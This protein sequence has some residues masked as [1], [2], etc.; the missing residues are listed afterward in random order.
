LVDFRRRLAKTDPGKIL[1][2]I[3]L[4]ETLDRA[5]DKGELRRAQEAILKRWHAEY[6]T[7]K[8]VVLKL[9]TGQGKTLI[10]L[11]IL[12][13][14]LNEN[15]G[16]AVYLCP[17]TFLIR[18]TCE[19]AKQFGV[20]YCLA[21]PD[22]PADFIDGKSLLITSVQKL[23]NGLT[24]FRLG[25]RSVPVATLVMDD[26]H[27]CVEDIREQLTIRLPRSHPAYQGLRELFAATLEEQGA[28]TWADIRANHYDALMLVPYWDWHDKH[29][30]VV[31]I[32]ASHSGD[33]E[34]KY[35][36]QLLRDQIN[37]CH[38]VVSGEALEIAPHLPPL[39]LFGSYH[40]ATH[41]VFMSATVTDDS[42]LVKG[43]RLSPDTIRRP[44]VYDKERWS[45]EKMILLPSLIHPSLD[46]GYIIS[47]FGGPK[48][49]RTYGVVALC[50][51]AARTKGWE[52]KGATITTKKTIDRAL[53]GLKKGHC[54]DTVVV[55]NRYDGIVLPDDAC[56][57]LIFDS[58]PHSDSLIDR[59][60]E[61]CRANSDSTAMRLARTIEQG[62]G[63]S[64]RGEKDYSVVLMTGE[65]LVKTVR[66]Q[67][68]RRH[69]S[70]QTRAQIEIGLEIAEMA[71][72]DDKDLPPLDV[73]RGVINKCL[74]RDED[75]KRFYV[76]HMDA[77]EPVPSTSKALDVFQLELEAELASASGDP[78]AAIT[79][80][81][82][83][84]DSYIT[85]DADK[86]W[87]LQEMGRYAYL[88]SKADSN[89]R[90]V[91]AHL[92]N[93]YVL[94]PRDGMKVD[95]L[96]ISQ[97]RVTKVI[98]WIR[99]FTDYSDLSVTLDD[100]VSRLQFGV[101]A[102]SFEQALGELGEALGFECQRPDKEWGRGP[103]NLWALRDGQ[104]LLIEC[105]NQ[106]HADRKEVYKDEAGQMNTSCAWFAQTY[107]GAT[108]K[109]ILITPAS[110]LGPGAALADDVELMRKS[111]LAKLLRN[112]RAFFAE[113]KSLDFKDLSAKAVQQL[114]DTHALSVEKLLKDYSRKARPAN[115]A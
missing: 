65:E 30:E 79:V 26:S 4:Y 74:K 115:G 50:P 80:V 53:D 106:V 96:V 114:I 62:L 20:R 38:C 3:A 61:S 64:V 110:K 56:R 97:Q 35:A 22:L 82:R 91:A 71:Q 21:E 72:E 100:I 49:G 103:D 43:L 14:K 104:Y 99:R 42:F 31:S 85:D 102:D 78:Q 18:Q 76:E 17:N 8:D 84:I 81:Q 16:P 57:L 52:A 83:L 75:W 63:R 34:I 108:A 58:R 12:Q 1:D 13:S 24:K 27:A 36:W 7:Q 70:P 54:N 23:F 107:A 46:V 51:S 113:F 28:G 25:S 45:G 10:G 95:K 67:A 111:D 29:S 89:S 48:S 68:S 105:K 87:Y 9:H 39:D 55:V 112:V 60:S 44:L 101:K 5:S 86:G 109:K 2:P 90:Q 59:Y 33:D 47:T 94:K 32:L 77:V 88:I 15:G 37:N 11:L 93:R 92:K 6:R 98:G 69:L 41:R 73:L 19:Q 66:S 40:R